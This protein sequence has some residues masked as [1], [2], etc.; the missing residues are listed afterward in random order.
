MNRI[1]FEHFVAVVQEDHM[2]FE[3]IRAKIIEY[4]EKNGSTLKSIYDKY[5]GTKGTINLQSLQ[6]L[7]IHNS[8]SLTSLY[9][10]VILLSTQI[11]VQHGLD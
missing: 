11:R 9:F 3:K 10:Q 4:K 1:S 2:N 6:V 5:S 7:P 8:S